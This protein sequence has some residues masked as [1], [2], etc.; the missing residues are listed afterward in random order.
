V[1]VARRLGLDVAEPRLLQETNNTVLWLWPNPVIA[2]VGTREESAEDL[3][4]EH[5]VASALAAVG[6]PAA[7]PLAETPPVRDPTTGFV[8]TLWHR[9]E[10]DP[11]G[12]APAPLVGRSLRRLH[13]A[14]AAC[15]L[16]LQ[17]FR[18]SFERA[19]AALSDDRRLPAIDPVDR[20]FLRAAIDDLV[21]ELD[22]R[23]HRERALHG[24]PHQGNYLRTPAGVR[25]ID[26]ESACRGPLEWDLA[27]LP[28]DAWGVFGEVDLRLLQLLRMLNSARSATWSLARIRFPEMRRYGEYHL[29][30]LRQRWQRS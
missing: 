18:E 19:R 9:L 8:V 13:D 5:E 11:S 24:E 3:V 27:F 29:E 21:A 25:W 14:L 20:A 10:H 17:S 2:K 28:E 7:R 4:R 30:V 6:A 1:D 12:H 23:P 22:R 15:N 16:R 26:F